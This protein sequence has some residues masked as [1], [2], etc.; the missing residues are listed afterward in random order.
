LAEASLLRE[1]GLDSETV[2]AL[3]EVSAAIA[4]ELDPWRVAQLVVDRAS[5]LVGADAARL[6]L[7]DPEAK[8]LRVLARS[9]ACLLRGAEEIADLGESVIGQVLRRREPVLV[10]DYQHWEFA[11]PE[12]LARGV[13]S[14]IGVPLLVND[15]PVGTIVL[16]NYQ[17]RTFT[18]GQVALLRLFAGQVAPALEAARLH[19]ESEARRRRAEEAEEQVRAF[20]AE[21]EQRVH[22]RTVELEAANSELEAF[23]YSVSH[24]LRAPLR[25]IDGFCQLLLEDYGHG[26]DDDAQG[27]LRRAR[28][29]PASAWPASSTICSSC[30]A[31]PAP[32]CAASALI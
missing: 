31:S 15:Q 21:L 10:D 27:Y 18:G 22:E 30:H 6:W 5:T 9:D 4:G 8:L 20:N 11:L 16:H 24:D 2:R 29:P 7:W 1:V 23:C 19:T 17:P 12:V 25:S 3:L 14:A 28:G 13:R 32:R 26:L